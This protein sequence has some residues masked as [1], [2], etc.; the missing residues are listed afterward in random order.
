MRRLLAAIWLLSACSGPPGE[1]VGYEPPATTPYGHRP[2]LQ[3]QYLKAHRAAW[4][5]QVSE[6]TDEWLEK[7]LQGEEAGSNGSW[8]GCCEAT[9]NVTRGWYRGMD[10]GNRFIARIAVKSDRPGEI[11]EK[12]RRLRK[13][14]ADHPVNDW[15]LADSYIPDDL[16]EVPDP[17]GSVIRVYRDATRTKIHEVRQVRDGKNHGRCESYDVN[18]SLREV[19]RWVDGIQEGEEIRYSDTGLVHGRV[20]YRAGKREGPEVWFHDD[21]FLAHYQ[22][23]QAGLEHGRQIDWDESGNPVRLFR[24]S[25]G[26]KSGRCLSF[27]SQGVQIE[28]FEAGKRVG[29]APGVSPNDLP[30]DERPDELRRLRERYRR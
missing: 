20:T 1:T 25:S 23:L 6:V 29:E 12:V 17:G 27:T 22:E 3:A 24:W 14:I 19:S 16:V 21:G 5:R 28:I 11:L 2:L 18:G 15:Y 26:K 7:R 13:E 8:A 9:P 30:P 4:N 10:D